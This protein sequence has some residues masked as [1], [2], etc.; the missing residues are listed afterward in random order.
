MSTALMRVYDGSGGLV[1]D[2]STAGGGVVVDFKSYAGGS[3]DTLTY[4]SFAG[5]SV[6]VL[7]MNGYQPEESDDFGVT[8][9]TSL[10]YPRVTVASR[11]FDRSF[12]V[13]V[14]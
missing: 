7:S 2:T 14:Y 11:S 3:S 8:T 6:S 4:P 5:K 1:F 13:M 12:I 9:D 10:G